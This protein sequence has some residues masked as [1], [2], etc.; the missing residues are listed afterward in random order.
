M[1]KTL[2]E[3]AA[4]ILG[5][6]IA[7]KRASA[8]KFGAGY[9][10]SYAGSQ[11]QNDTRVAGGAKTPTGDVEADFG[12]DEDDNGQKKSQSGLTDKATYPGATPP[13][14]SQPKPD[15]HSGKN[16]KGEKVAKV[17]DSGVVEEE[18]NKGDNADQ[19]G[20]QDDFL[21]PNSEKNGNK[22]NGIQEEDDN[23]DDDKDE[24][25]EDDDDKEEKSV[26]ESRAH[27][28]LRKFAELRSR[29]YEE[30]DEDNDDDEDD[31]GGK[32]DHDEDDEDDDKKQVDEEGSAGF[33]GKL[34]STNAG[35]EKK[36]PDSSDAKDTPADE[37]IDIPDAEP[38][39]SIV[40][41][42]FAKKG[43]D[44]SIKEAMEA[45]FAGENISESF[46]KKARTIFEAA[47]LERTTEICELIEDAYVNQLEAVTQQL[48]EEQTEKVDAYLNYVVEQWVQDNE[49][50]I[51][52]GLRTEL[53]EDFISGLR[54]LF[55][56][57][58]I[59]IPEDK[60]NIVEEL[61]SR[62]DE[63]EETLSEEVARNVE[64]KKELNESHKAMV[65]SAFAEGLTET[66]F[67]KLCKLSEGVS[68]DDIDNFAEKVQTLKESYF[69]SKSSEQ[70]AKKTV[71]KSTSDRRQL[72]E[73]SVIGDERGTVTEVS[74]DANIN[75]YAQALGRLAGT[76]KV[77][78]S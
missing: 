5:G 30:K 31:H 67:S 15:I 28:A 61:A 18:G 68:F 76:S 53:A 27:R 4:D 42:Y 7:A 21:G 10:R 12:Y 56:E 19:D 54:N 65:L 13:I 11:P 70:P 17:N 35:V 47:V 55:V 24:D 6:N 63:L 72:D 51:E 64:I 14:G 3:A 26:N 20:N 45:L 78:K 59:D 49:I 43:A 74:T 69:D 39:D 44:E 8:E 37:N 34:S 2:A 32:S 77:Q 66:Q 33:N 75:K 41:S 1:P 57:H 48:E 46:I 58:Y 73:Q 62:V 23:D 16:L 9:D 25:K 36:F 50:A 52:R 40:K 22:L 71:E 38:V 60:L 29:L